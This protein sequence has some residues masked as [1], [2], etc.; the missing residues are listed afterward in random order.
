MLIGI[1]G[2]TNTGKSTFFKA[3]TLVDAEISNRVFTT[4]KPNVGAGHVMAE[5]PC[6]RLGVKCSPV[7][8]ECVGG[9]RLM[10]VKLIDVAGL[11]PG[12][13]EGRGLGNQFLSDIMEASGMVH[14]VDA[15]GGTDSDGNP[16]TPGSHDPEEDIEFLP[17]EIDRWILGILNKSWG[18]ISRQSKSGSG[19]EDLVCR[20]LSGLGMPA[21]VIAG[22]IKECGIS[23]GSEE[24]DLLGFVRVLRERGKPIIVAANKIDLPEAQRN[25]GRL[26]SGEDLVPCS[27]DSELALREAAR[28][29]LIDYAQGDSFQVKGRLS[30]GQQRALDFIRANVIQRYGSTGVQNCLDR[31]VFGR[32]GMVAVYPV[33]DINKLSDRKGNVL[34]DAF[35][36]RKG[37]RLK[38]FAER[39]HTDLARGFAGG[40]DVERKKLGADYVLKDG[41]VVEILFR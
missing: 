37:T 31:L 29:G 25:Y 1:V 23:A 16:V 21:D 9:L 39:V 24:G 22:A 38:E 14:V 40:L 18:R 3:A 33:A 32:L 17:R 13:H 35:L 28:S 27:A 7:N 4:I 15:S 2:K 36:V 10:P 26:A 12:A 19:L 41:D 20:Q 11:V 6:K 5:C 34:P 30:E 8:S